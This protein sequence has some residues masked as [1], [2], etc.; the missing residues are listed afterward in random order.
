LRIRLAA[1]RAVG[2]AARAQD[3]GAADS[4]ELDIERRAQV[5][6]LLGR[7]ASAGPL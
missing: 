1:A 7:R 2:V 3:P 6:S 4:R 5:A